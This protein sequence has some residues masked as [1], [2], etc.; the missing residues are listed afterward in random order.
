[1]GGLD[2]VGGSHQVRCM[3]FLRLIVISCLAP[4]ILQADETPLPLGAADLAPNPLL[5]SFKPTTSK[6][7]TVDLDEAFKVEA[8]K[9]L[10]LEYEV[11]PLTELELLKREN[12]ALKLR[13]AELERRLAAVEARLSEQ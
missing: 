1:M 9:Q 2:F 4:L 5:D 6:I 10:D 8:I 12:A 7:S 13:V 3:L 11:E